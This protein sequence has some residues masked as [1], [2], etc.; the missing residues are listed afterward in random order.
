MYCLI[1][2]L[3]TQACISASY[4]PLYRCFR[5]MFPP[6]GI[7]TPAEWQRRVGKYRW[8]VGRKSIQRLQWLTAASCSW[9][10]VFRWISMWQFTS[11][12]RKERRKKSMNGLSAGKWPFLVICPLT[13]KER[14]AHLCRNYLGSQWQAIQ[15]RFT[16]LYFDF[17]VLLLFC[18]FNFY[19]GNK[20]ITPTTKI[21]ER[22]IGS[23]WQ[24]PSSARKYVTGRF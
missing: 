19:R 8:K 9:H 6:A 24:A 3:V 22:T 1:L 7:L 2:Y 13:R 12:A 4:A 15:T 18:L 5:E 16:Y 14:R 17:H 10:L 21:V 20:S 23:I 11:G